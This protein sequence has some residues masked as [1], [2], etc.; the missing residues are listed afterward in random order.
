MVHF[1]VGTICLW[2]KICT[3][4]LWHTA[5]FI[6]GPFFPNSWSAAVGRCIFLIYIHP[7]NKCSKINEIV[8]SERWIV[9]I[10]IYPRKF[11]SPMNIS[12]IY[13]LIIF[14]S[15]DSSMCT[16]IRGV[17]KPCLI[18]KVNLEPFPWIFTVFLIQLYYLQAQTA[19]IWSLTN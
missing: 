4:C 16:M 8:I 13:N 12:A 9:I 17:Y 1:T 2:L 3:L 10:S 14:R 6:S 11:Y 15:V 18:F 7:I 5:G 19:V